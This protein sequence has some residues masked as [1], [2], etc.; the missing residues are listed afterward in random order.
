MLTRRQR[1]NRCG[2]DGQLTTVESIRDG[3]VNGS[4]DAV[5]DHV[6]ISRVLLQKQ[7]TLFQRQC[8][9]QLLRSTSQLVDRDRRV[10]TDTTQSLTIGTNQFHQFFQRTRLS[11][12]RDRMRPFDASEMTLRQHAIS[13]NRGDLSVPAFVAK[14][15]DYIDRGQPRSQDHDVLVFTWKV[16]VPVLPWIATIASVVGELLRTGQTSR[17]LVA[18]RQQNRFCFDRLTLF[19]HHH[20]ALI[21]TRLNATRN[22]V[23]SRI[24]HHFALHMRS[25]VGRSQVVRRHPT[26][27]ITKDSTRNERLTKR[28][29]I[30]RIEF[31]A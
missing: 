21:R 15:H 10:L 26:D 29:V 14:R 20:A 6:P 30:D 16:L 22:D 5:A 8:F 27:V 2:R 4:R 25:R 11:I 18:G 17:R 19:Q 28:V 3:I 7:L 13:R 24:F 12:I 9:P 23:H 31:R 1:F